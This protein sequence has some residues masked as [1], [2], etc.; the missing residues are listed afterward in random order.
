MTN[1]NGFDD[2]DTQVTA[3]E[4]YTNEDTMQT[5][6]EM[7]IQEFTDKMRDRYKSDSYAAGYFS[8]WVRQFGEADPKVACDIITQLKAQLHDGEF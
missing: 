2:F 8:A 7:V 6:L 1:Q 3:E 5:E 4:F